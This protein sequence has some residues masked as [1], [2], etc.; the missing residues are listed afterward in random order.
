MDA[1]LGAFFPVPSWNSAENQRRRELRSLAEVTLFAETLT[2]AAR[3]PRLK[4]MVLTI[5]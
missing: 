3:H 1:G 5:R 4:S 2:V